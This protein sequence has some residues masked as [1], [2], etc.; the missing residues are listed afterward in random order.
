MALAEPKD[1]ATNHFNPDANFE[2]LFYGDDY[3][4]L[5]DPIPKVAHFIY[6]T[7]PPINWI[8]YLAIKGAIQNLKAVKVKIWM[9]QD[10]ILEGDLW[11]RVRKMPKVQLCP[12]EI[13]QSVY[14]V[15]ID[16]DTG[17]SDVLRLKILYEEGGT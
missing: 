17:K 11:E 10:S 6:T 3:S 1:P 2:L 15:K 9:P 5:R 12:I 16:D 7:T 8:N 4:Y 14:G 13:P